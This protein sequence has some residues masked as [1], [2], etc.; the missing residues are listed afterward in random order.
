MDPEGPNL[1]R[2]YMPTL[3]ALKMELARF[4]VLLSLRHP[5]LHAHIQG[6]G[7]PSVLYVSQ[8][9]ARCP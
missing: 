5:R 6:H 8:V 2:M 4:E 9:S 3:D 7:V 1:R